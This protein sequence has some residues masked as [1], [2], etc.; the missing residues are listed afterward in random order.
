MTTTIR[1]TG[2]ISGNHTLANKLRG[3][4]EEKREMFNSFILI[5]SSKKEAVKAIRNAYNELCN[6]EPEMKGR[7]GGIRVNADRTSLYYDASQAIID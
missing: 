2:Q 6:E 1:I 7:F 5:Y 4:I 3:A